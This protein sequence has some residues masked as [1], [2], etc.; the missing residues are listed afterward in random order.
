MGVFIK[1]EL[2]PERI[3][4]ELAPR[5]IAVC[6]VN[7]FAQNETRVHVQP[8]NED[9]CTLC[10]LC[11]ELAPRGAVTIHKLYKDGTLVSRGESPK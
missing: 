1:I 6:P 9:E 2:D 10:E 3:A 8:E 11:L 4:P 5:L 7:I